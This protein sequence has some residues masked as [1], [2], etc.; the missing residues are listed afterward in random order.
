MIST[1]KQNGHSLSEIKMA[2]DQTYLC[3]MLNE[4]TGFNTVTH[5][6]GATSFL[7]PR[8][9]LESTEAPFGYKILEGL[10]ERTMQN[11]ITPGTKI[12]IS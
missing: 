12:K 6:C 8:T 9:Y 2:D 4:H 10:D 11:N 7:L 1:S 3:S 5:S